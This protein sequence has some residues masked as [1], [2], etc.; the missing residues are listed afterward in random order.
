MYSI[1]KKKVIQRFLLLVAILA[2]S[3]CFSKVINAQ[4]TLFDNLKLKSTDMPDYTLSSEWVAFPEKGEGS[5]YV[6]LKTSPFL[7]MPD[8]DTVKPY[9]PKLEFH[10]LKQFWVNNLESQNQNEVKDTLDVVYVIFDTLS[11]ALCALKSKALSIS[12]LSS[13]YPGSGDYALTASGTVTFVRGKILVHIFT[14]KYINIGDP[15]LNAITNTLIQ[16]ID[17]HYSDINITYDDI[18]ND[19]HILEHMDFIVEDDGVQRYGSIQSNVLQSLEPKL[20]ANI[21][22]AKSAIEGGGDPAAAKAQAINS[23]NTFI[24]EV[25]VLSTPLPEGRFIRGTTG[26]EGLGKHIQEPAANALIKEAQSIIDEL[27]KRVSER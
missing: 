25:Q 4:T 24:N 15:T 3:L 18:I 14:D 11:Q 2:L 27:K 7:G 16:R 1:T 17:T 13:P 5:W 19:L 12:A 9:V 10:E 20:G 21:N 26:G 6:I 22:A 8:Y 23:L